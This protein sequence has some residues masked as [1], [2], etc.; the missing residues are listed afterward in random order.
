ME[1]LFRIKLSAVIG[2][3]Q[4]TAINFVAINQVG[5][6]ARFPTRMERVQSIMLKAM[7]AMS[8]YVERYADEGFVLNRRF[9]VMIRSIERA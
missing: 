7:F 8:I 5:E 3:I 6:R 2:N 1:I 4:R 9:I